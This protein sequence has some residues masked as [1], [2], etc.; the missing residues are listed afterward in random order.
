M[1]L[2][3]RDSNIEAELVI[4]TRG[5]I[6]VLQVYFRAEGE[7]KGPA[8]V[9]VVNDL[10]WFDTGERGWACN[11]CCGKE[12][13]ND[14]GAPIPDFV[15]TSPFGDFPAVEDMVTFRVNRGAT[16]ADG[17]VGERVEV[18]EQLAL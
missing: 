16:N 7:I 10:C 2:G 3:T 6:I 18:K 14:W 4:R 17:E 5:D 9:H 1:S 12:V 8:V 13:T 15:M 11:M